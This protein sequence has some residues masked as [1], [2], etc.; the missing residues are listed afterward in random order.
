[1]ELFYAWLI[2]TPI[3]FILNWIVINIFRSD[4]V[5]VTVLGL[6]CYVFL[7][8]VPILQLLVLVFSVFIIV[9][10]YEY[11]KFFHK[12]ILERTDL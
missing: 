3:A 5:D 12:V 4:G 1:M 11:L 7:S 10:K 6:I 8:V 2:A 9:E